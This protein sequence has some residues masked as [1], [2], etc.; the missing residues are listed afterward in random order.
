FSVSSLD[1]RIQMLP[2]AGPPV[3]DTAVTLGAVLDHSLQSSLAT[4]YVQARHQSH[5]ANISMCWERRITDQ[6][7]RPDGCLSAAFSRENEACL[8]RGYADSLALFPER[9]S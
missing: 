5:A 2:P 7:L 3:T 9:P 4:D 6:A 1:I 8:V